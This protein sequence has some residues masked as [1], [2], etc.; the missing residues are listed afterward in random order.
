MCE[1]APR[2]VAEGEVRDGLRAGL[3]KAG[4]EAGGVG[5]ACCVYV[6]VYVCVYTCV[7]GQTRRPYTI[8]CGEEV[9]DREG[10]RSL[11]AKSTST[12]ISRPSWP[13]EAKAGDTPL[14]TL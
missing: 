11:S 1:Y 6:C 13:P 9:G 8:V 12:L 7:V 10:E 2:H 14:S 4:D 3:A 5:E